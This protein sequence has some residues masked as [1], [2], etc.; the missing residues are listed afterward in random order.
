MNRSLNIAFFHNLPS[1]GAL[2]AL[3]EKIKLFENQGHRVSLFSFS[4]SEQEFLPPPNIS[5]DSFVADLAF[6]GPLKFHRYFNA[7]RLCAE[8]INE[9]YADIVY[10]DKCRFIG[11]PPILRYLKK[12]NIFYLHEPLGVREYLVKA[13]KTESDASPMLRDYLKLPFLAKL[14]K[15]LSIPERTWIK[16]QDQ[17]SAHAAARVWTCSEFAK[18]WILR[19]YG[20]HAEVAYQGVNIDFFQ[21][22]DKKKK[23]DQVLSVGRIEPRKGHNFLVEALSLIERDQ[24]PRLVVVCDE[25]TE[26]STFELK[27]IAHRS[28]VELEVVY[29]PT[30]D[31]LRN[32]YQESK[33]VLCAGICEPF[34]LVPLEAMACETPVIAVNEGG[35]METLLEGE[36]GYLLP[37]DANVWALRIAALLKNPDELFRLGATGRSLVVS[38]WTWQCFLNS[39][40]NLIEQGLSH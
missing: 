34:G 19:V 20:I 3:Y 39:I 38:K 11:S 29:R 10:V 27:D 13:Q 15:A 1:G 17:R 8:K 7:T 40:T 5:G 22:S 30:Q 2:R 33:L 28:G 24:R 9:S 37:R 26:A 23:S 18:E 31:L 14:R 32:L 12:N 16:W 6:A 36:N 25:A 35:Y 21:P 4:T